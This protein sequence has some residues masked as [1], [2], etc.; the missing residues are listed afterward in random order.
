[1]K[2]KSWKALS[3]VLAAAVGLGITL[4]PGAAES[5]EALA[6][7]KSG[8]ARVRT[9]NVRMKAADNRKENADSI[10]KEEITLENLKQVTERLRNVSVTQGKAYVDVNNSPLLVS[11]LIGEIY[12]HPKNTPKEQKEQTAMTGRL[13]AIARYAYQKLTPQEREAIP[14]IPEGLGYEYPGAG[15]AD[16]FVST[17]DPS[18]DN[19]LNTAPTKKKE[20]LVVSFGTSYT[21]SR[22]ADIGGIEKALQQAYPD[23]DVRRAFTSQI[24]INHILARDDEEILTVREAMEKARA[25][26]VT[27][28][29]VQPTTLMHGTEYDLM[30]QNVKANRG[31]MRVAFAEPLLGSAS[32]SDEVTNT[33]K[34]SVAKAAAAASAAGIGAADIQSV[35]KDTAVVLLGHGT[36]HRAASAYNQMQYTVKEL[37]YSNVFIGTVEGKPEETEVSAVVKKVKAAGFR[38]VVLRPLMVV[39]GDHANNDMAGTE[40][41]SWSSR[42]RSAGLS[43]TNQI[44]G[45]GEIPAI[46]QLYVDHTKNAVR[47]IE[48]IQNQIRKTQ[49]MRV[50]SFSGKAMKNRRIRLS[51]KKLSGADYYE[52]EMAKTKNGEYTRIGR[53]KMPGMTTKAFRAGRRISFR[54]RGVRNVDGE[55]IYTGWS[56]KMTV[57]V[58]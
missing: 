38:K 27:D 14:P 29:I 23:W 37:G 48:S 6:A 47:S 44:A 21:D 17:G 43:V 25:A 58:K 55:T 51:W 46:R 31:K 54:V 28:L 12:I 40:E 50:R 2:R 1:M 49:K 53:T 5:G 11:G 18:R 32:D 33:D 15:G 16:Y 4:T 24:I 45:L 22:A 8:N 42:F 7:E 57:R 39:A 10:R 35:P 36:S 20:I 13:G 26:G 3:V 56:K 19:P 41:D 52:V 34:K 9:E 30:V